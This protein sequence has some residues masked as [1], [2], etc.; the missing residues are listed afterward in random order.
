MRRINI[1]NLQADM[2][3]A[4]N[5]FSSEGRILLSSGVMLSAPYIERLLSLGIASVYIKDDIFGDIDHIPEVISEKTRIDTVKIVRD[6]FNNMERNHKLNVRLIKDVVNNLVE[7]LLFNPNVLVNLTDIRSY[8]D[9]TFAHS[10]NV[11]ILSLMTGV[12]LSYDDIKLKDLGVGALLHDIGKIKLDK[13]TL[14]KAD[15]LTREEYFE[16][17][18]HAESGFEI[19]RKYDDISLLSAHIA[20]QHHERWNGTGYPRGL[21]G[22]DIHEYGRIVAVADV[23]DALLA[24][25]PYRSSYSVNQAITILQRMAGTYLDPRCITALIANVAVYPIGSIVELNSGV[26]GIVVDVNKEMPTRPVVRVVYNSNSERLNHPHEVDL[27]KLSTIIIVKALNDK[28][29]D[30]LTKKT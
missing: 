20:F 15:D 13:G 7:E 9:Y 12:T 21:S 29:L 19:L 23:Y 22:N 6:S 14:N 3:V 10:V 5:I 1:E 17:K 4:R 2:I 24:D 26:V 11:C 30:E 8:D 16:V 25:R 27:S 28:D 18:Q